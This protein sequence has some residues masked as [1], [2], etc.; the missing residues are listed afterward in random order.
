MIVVEFVRIRMGF[1]VLTGTPGRLAWND[2]WYGT[3]NLP[4]FRILSGCAAS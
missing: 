2:G 3:T 4:I 1:C